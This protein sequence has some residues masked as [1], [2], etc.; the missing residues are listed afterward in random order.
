[1]SDEF[2]FIKPTEKKSEPK[3]QTFTP[4][5]ASESGEFIFVAPPKPEDKR[6]GEEMA[7]AAGAGAAASRP[8]APRRWPPP[9]AVPL[10][11]PPAG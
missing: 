3:V 6:K 4:D 7:E 8:P 5:A 10:R 2:V 1:M 11:S 9:G